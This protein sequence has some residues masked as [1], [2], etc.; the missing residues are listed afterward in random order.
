MFQFTHLWRC[1]AWIL[2]PVPSTW[3]F[4]SRTCEGATIIQQKIRNYS[5]GFNSRTCEGATKSSPK[6]LGG[7][8][9]QFTHLWRCDEILLMTLGINMVSIH[10]PVKVRRL[11]VALPPLLTPFQFTHLWRC[12][13][14]NW[15]ERLP[16]LFQFTHLWRCDPFGK[17]LCVS[18]AVSI[19][20]PVKVR[21]VLASSCL[22]WRR[23]NSRTCE[24]ATDA[25]GSLYETDAV[26][27]HAP[28]KVRQQN[29]NY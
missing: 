5:H 1:D 14:F 21:H 27:I 16:K 10:A 4:N 17:V 15:I 29:H 7:I 28:V 6:P 12:D 11:N 25:T 8:T 26:S 18:T 23:F 3:S 20:A 2:L 13:C 22:P 24:G 19:H 9:F